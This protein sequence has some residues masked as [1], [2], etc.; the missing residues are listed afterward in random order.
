[1]PSPSNRFDVGRG[2]ELAENLINIDLYRIR[3]KTIVTKNHAHG[4]LG[5]QLLDQFFGYA[6]VKAGYQVIRL[7]I[8]EIDGLFLNGLFAVFVVRVFGTD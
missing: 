4:L 7:V 8:D 6:L 5:G 1:L 2:G 3:H